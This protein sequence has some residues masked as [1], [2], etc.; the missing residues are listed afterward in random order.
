MMPRIRLGDS[1]L[2]VTELIYAHKKY[3]NRL[4]LQ[5]VSDRNIH[6]YFMC[7]KHY[8]VEHPRLRPLGRNTM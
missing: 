3:V 1:Q 4:F 8:T 7:I 5:N 2:D 6:V